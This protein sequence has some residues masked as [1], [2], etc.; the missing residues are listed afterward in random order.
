M[1]NNRQ[2]VADINFSNRF[3]YWLTIQNCTGKVLPPAAIEKHLSTKR[4]YEA[5][6]HIGIA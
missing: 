6:P 2:S 3:V 1:S 5:S 4:S